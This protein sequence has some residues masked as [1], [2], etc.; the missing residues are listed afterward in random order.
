MKFLRKV[1]TNSMI[2][3]IC[4]FLAVFG[5]GMG[6]LTV[7]DRQLLWGIL[8]LT[9]GVAVFI[10]GRI[11]ASKGDAVEEPRHTWWRNR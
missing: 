5:V 2:G 11:I 3:L 10:A 8:Y 9:G 7:V 6:L 4:T 1:F